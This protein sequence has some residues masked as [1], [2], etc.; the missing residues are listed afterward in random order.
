MAGRKTSIY[1]SEELAV[2]CKADGRPL[3]D[4]LRAGL[5]AERPEDMIRRV[6]TEAVR[7]ELAANRGAE[8]A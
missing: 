1:L 6:V 5:A 8:R 4:I 3:A 2:A 7:S